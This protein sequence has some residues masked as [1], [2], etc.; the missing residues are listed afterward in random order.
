MFQVREEGKAK[1]LP[2]EQSK[3]F[4]RVTA[5]ILFILIRYIR[6]IHLP[7]AFL[8]VKFKFPGE[9]DWVKLKRVLKYL[10]GDKH[11]KLT[12]SVEFL[13]IIKWWVDASDSHHMNCKGRGGYSIS[14]VKG[15]IVSFSKK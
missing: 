11:M 6:D 5:K 13:S 3:I 7:V 1:R 12:L 2:E 9:D 4:H 8:T 15:Y 10:K 14:I